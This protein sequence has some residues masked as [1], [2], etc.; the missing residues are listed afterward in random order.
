MKDGEISSDSEKTPSV[1]EVPTK[2]RANYMWLETVH[3]TKMGHAPRLHATERCSPRTCRQRNRENFSTDIR[4]PMT[5]TR[6]AI[7]RW[8]QQ[9]KEKIVKILPGNCRRTRSVTGEL[10]NDG[11]NTIL[12]IDKHLISI[13]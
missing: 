8:I 12:I 2:N 10:T 1:L 11:I 3:Y 7:N 4:L 5:E 9:V 6:N 13:L